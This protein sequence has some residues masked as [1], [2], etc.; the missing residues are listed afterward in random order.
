[1]KAIVGLIGIL[2]LLSACAQEE[3]GYTDISPTELA[4]LLDSGD[5]ILLIDVHIPEQEHINGTD[6]VI[7]YTNKEGL[8][9]AIPAKDTRV[10]LYCRSG[11]MSQYAAQE[12]AAAGYTNVHN[13]AGGMNAWR[14]EVEE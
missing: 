6:Y 8:K 5:D 1:M 9:A 3:P 7:P 14:A 2:L 12:L 13:L 11:S 4:S 10:V